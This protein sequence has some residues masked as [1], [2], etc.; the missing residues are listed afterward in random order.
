M[1]LDG[2][3]TLSFGSDNFVQIFNVRKLTSTVLE[4]LNENE[5][6]CEHCDSIQ[7]T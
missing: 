1:L 5:H 4:S 7:T 3:A 6:V 2:L